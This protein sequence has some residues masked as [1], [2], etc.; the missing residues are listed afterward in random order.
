MIS[1][2]IN[3]PNR[4]QLTRDILVDMLLD[5]D[6]NPA[7]GDPDL[8]GAD[9]AIELFREVVLFKWDGT[10]HPTPR[11]PAGDLAHLFLGGGVTINISAVE[12]G[13]TKKFGFGVIALSGIV[14]NETTGEPDFTNAVSDVA[15]AASAGFYSYDVK[16]APARVV[17]KSLKTAPTSP[18]AGKTFT[19]R[20]AATRS[21]RAPRS[22][23]GASTA[24]PGQARGAS[25]RSRRGSWAARRSACSRCLQTPRARRC[26]GRSRRSSSRA[27]ARAAVQREDPLEEHRAPRGADI[28]RS[29]G[30]GGHRRRIGERQRDQPHDGF[31]DALGEDPA[32]PDIA[33]V[34]VSNNDE[35]T[36]TFRIALPNRPT[37]GND[38][39]LAVDR[40]RLERGDGAHRQRDRLSPALRLLSPW[41]PAALAADLRAF[42]VHFRCEAAV[43]VRVG[44]GGHDRP[45][46]PGNTRR[47]R[48]FLNAMDGIVFDPVAKTF[49]LSNAHGDAA[50]DASAPSPWSYEVKLG[51]SRLLVQRFATTPA[52]PAAGKTFL[53]RL[54]VKR[55]DSGAL[56][57]TG[58]AWPATPPS[59]ALGLRV[60][61][62]GFAQ[63][64][65]LCV[66]RVPQDVTGVLL[67][68]SIAPT[69]SGKTAKKSFALKAS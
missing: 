5:T 27:A 40:R 14:F 67:R 29:T 25:S 20:M 16:V 60:Q 52:K 33:T 24:S 1:F 10:P 26:A 11:R 63:G 46:E 7:T 21:D 50:P 13:N 42:R 19:V 53:A 8:L 64:A 37:L 45:A 44:A 54:K 62:S 15:P 32:A 61:R 68:G 4:A 3:I 35:G 56:V 22:S 12:L 39:V 9:Y 47:F 6:A 23:T 36:L 65:A 49:D 2:K 38:M 48:L 31:D 57:T 58:K 30:P 34:R 66:W 17:F 69:F 55:D 59:A 18:K 51:P 28:P 41:R 43:L